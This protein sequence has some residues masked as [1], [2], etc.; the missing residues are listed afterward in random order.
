MA[1]LDTI[2]KMLDTMFKI[3][4]FLQMDYVHQ[5]E[6]DAIINNFP[7]NSSSSNSD[8]VSDDDFSKF[9]NSF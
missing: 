6:I 9:L 8:E 2:K 5:S 1:T 3:P 4:E 7:C